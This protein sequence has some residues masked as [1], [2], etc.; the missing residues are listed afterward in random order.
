MI[1]SEL[2]GKDGKGDS[3]VVKYRLSNYYVKDDEE[4]NYLP[5]KGTMMTPAETI[6]DSKIFS[7]F[8]KLEKFKE[9]HVLNTYDSKI[10]EGDLS[11]IRKRKDMY[12][13]K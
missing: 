8:T 5:K 10:S 4:C 11:A 1:P 3:P 7:E 12:L 13:V 9:K 6:I 2:R